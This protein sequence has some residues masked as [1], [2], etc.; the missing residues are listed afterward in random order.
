[1]NDDGPMTAEQA[2]TLKSLAEAAYE[3][4]ALKPS[5]T[6]TEADIASRC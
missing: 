5:L 1:M 2:E 3:L 6:C 4:D